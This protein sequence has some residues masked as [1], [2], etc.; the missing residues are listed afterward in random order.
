MNQFAGMRSKIENEPDKEDKED[1]KWY[2]WRIGISLR[3]CAGLQPK[4]VFQS[5]LD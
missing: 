2:F 1:F 5:I 4:D 3:W